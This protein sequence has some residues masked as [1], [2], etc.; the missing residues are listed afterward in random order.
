MLEDFTV[1]SLTLQGKQGIVKLIYRG[2]VF[3]YDGTEEANGGYFCCKSRIC[4]KI[5]LSIGTSK[6][7]V[8]TIVHHCL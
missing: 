7:K 4:E 8:E 1:V 3:L 5:K 2:T 6:E